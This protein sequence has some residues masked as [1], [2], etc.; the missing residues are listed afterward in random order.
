MIKGVGQT[1]AC[2][3]FFITIQL[4]E[5][6]TALFTISDSMYG[7]NFYSATGL[8]GLHVGFALFSLGVVNY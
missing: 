1:I 8:H 7:T 6:T 2:T 3:G 4:K 5:Y